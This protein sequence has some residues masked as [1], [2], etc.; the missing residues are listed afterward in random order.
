MK[1]RLHEALKLAREAL[2]PPKSVS[3]PEDV[4]P[5]TH[6]RLQSLGYVE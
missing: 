1:A 4:S 3:L 2:E 5:E 6:Q